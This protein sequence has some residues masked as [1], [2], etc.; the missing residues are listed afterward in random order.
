M[1]RAFVSA[2]SMIAIATLLYDAGTCLAEPVVKETREGGTSAL[3]STLA[4]AAEKTYRIDLS[5]RHSPATERTDLI[6]NWESYRFGAFVC[7]NSNQF[8]GIEIYK[9]DRRLDPSNLTCLCHSH[10]SRITRA[11]QLGRDAP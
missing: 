7:F 2:L 6:K 5:Q 9:V 3:R 11:R 10:H 1:V 8:S 4:H